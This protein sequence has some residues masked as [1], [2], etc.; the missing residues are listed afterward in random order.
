MSANEKRNKD[1][2]MAS[3]LRNSGYPHGRRMGT[4]GPCPVCYRPGNHGGHCASGLDGQGSAANRR[5]NAKRF[6]V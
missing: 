4:P 2:E 1:K 6:T 3:H 5:R